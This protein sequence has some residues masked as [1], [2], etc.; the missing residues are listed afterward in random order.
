MNRRAELLLLVAIGS[1]VPTASVSAQTPNLKLAVLDG[2]GMENVQKQSVTGQLSLLWMRADPTILD[3]DPKTF[4]SFILM[5]NCNASERDYVSVMRAMSNEFDSG[6]I[7]AFYKPKVTEILSEVPDTFT[8]ILQQYPSSTGYASNFVLGQYDTAAGGF[9]FVN[10]AGVRLA[11]P[12]TLTSLAPGDAYSGR[13]SSPFN[14]SYRV[15]FPAVAFSQLRMNEQDARA[16]VAS[17]HDITGR[18]RPIYLQVD[19]EILPDAPQLSTPAP[20]PAAVARREFE[21]GRQMPAQNQILTFS[22]KVKK[23]TALNVNGG[24]PLGDLY[25]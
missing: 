19:L 22:A 23:V 4:R 14:V 6:S 13:C 24:R 5:N 16:F 8:V 11:K 10:A 9:P 2:P 15:T 3:K 25:P 18:P 17:I 21:L 1:M 12:V 20:P 7:V